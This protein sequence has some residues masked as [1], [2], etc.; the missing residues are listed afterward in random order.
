MLSE[1]PKAAM[2]ATQLRDDALLELSNARKETAFWE[3]RS[4]SLEI[5]VIICNGASDDGYSFEAGLLAGVG[6]MLLSALS[7]KWAAS[8]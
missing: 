3:D 5:S 2:E 1:N 7:I 4:D 6:V 8:E